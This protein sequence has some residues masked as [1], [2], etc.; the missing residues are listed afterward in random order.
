LNVR[1]WT[2]PEC[3]CRHDRDI[4]AALNVLTVGLEES[5]L[6]GVVRYFQTLVESETSALRSKDLKV[7]LLAETRNYE[8]DLVG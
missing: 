1:S 4:S 7:S 8:A 6:E 5:E 2:C 3:G